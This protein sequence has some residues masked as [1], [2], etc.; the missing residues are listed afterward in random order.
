[1]LKKEVSICVKRI[2][3]KYKCKQG[4]VQNRGGNRDGC[5]ERFETDTC[6]LKL[7]ANRKTEIIAE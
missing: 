6:S 5:D 7:K 4:A 2:I 3:R 1:M